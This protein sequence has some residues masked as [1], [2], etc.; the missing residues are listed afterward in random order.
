M[1]LNILNLRIFLYNELYL[2]SRRHT[3]STQNCGLTDLTAV[4]EIEM[5]RMRARE[6]AV[7]ERHLTLCQRIRVNLLPPPQ[8]SRCSFTSIKLIIL[9]ARGPA[10]EIQRG[11]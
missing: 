4:G 3:F 11:K 10:I 7:K 6:G 8:V 5:T 1:Y 9:Q 2:L